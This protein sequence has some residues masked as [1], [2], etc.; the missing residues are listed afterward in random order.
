MNSVII[1]YSYTGNNNA[2]AESVAR[3]LSVKHINISVQKPITMGSILMD[4]IFARTPKVQLDP[5]IMQQYD[6]IIFC[7]PIW[8]GQVAS[9]LRAYLNYLK[10]S[11]KAYGFISISGGADGANPKLDSELR[12]RTGTQSIILLDQHKADL[13][14]T[15]P[16]PTRKDTSA[17]RIGR[18]DTKRLTSTVIEEIKKII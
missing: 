4:M 6:L 9:P 2:L 13:L 15:N 16:K 12:K 14:P 11:P 7:A 5:D 18:E 17:Y 3:E 1:S 8:M 10:T